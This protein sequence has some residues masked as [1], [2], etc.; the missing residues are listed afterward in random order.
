MWVQLRS[1]QGPRLLLELGCT[2]GKVTL[3]RTETNLRLGPAASDAAGRLISTGFPR[4]NR[5][6]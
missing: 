3:T 1:A 2:S 5:F 6:G 4:S